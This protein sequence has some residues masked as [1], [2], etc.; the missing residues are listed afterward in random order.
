M[1][2]SGEGGW[3]MANDDIDIKVI[4][5]ATGAVLQKVGDEWLLNFTGP[6]GFGL[7][8]QGIPDH[9]LVDVLSSGYSPTGVIL[10]LERRMEVAGYLVH[11]RHPP[12][13]PEDSAE[14]GISFP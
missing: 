6:D 4:P 12:R 13:S 11:H 10:Y 7:D 2:S 5:H 1:S 8:V 14:W 3:H 9:Q